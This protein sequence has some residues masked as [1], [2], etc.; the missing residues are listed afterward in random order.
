[1]YYDIY[2]FKENKHCIFKNEELAIQF[3]K[4]LDNWGFGVI[5]DLEIFKKNFKNEKIIFMDF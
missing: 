5:A 3:S 1:M 2:F 4:P